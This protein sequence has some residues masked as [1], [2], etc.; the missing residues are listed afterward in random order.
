MT[1]VVEVELESEPKDVVVIKNVEVEPHSETNLIQR[2]VTKL[3]PEIEEAD[4][5]TMSGGDGE[6]LWVS[7]LGLFVHFFFVAIPR[8]IIRVVKM[9]PKSVKGQTVVITGGASGL[10]QRMAEMFALDHGA[11]VAI[12]DVDKVK[13]EETVNSIK[14]RGGTAK[15]W[16]CDITKDEDMNKVADEIRDEFGH[17]HIVICNAAILYFG[18]MMELTTAQL[19][20]AT[21]VNLMGTIITIRAFLP[22]MEKVNNGQ[23]VTVSSVAGFFGETYG[24]AYCPSKF[25]VRGVMESLE[26]EMRD[27]GLDGIKCTTV[28]PWFIRTPMILNMGMRPTSRLLPFMSV[29]RAAKQIIDAVLKEKSVSFVPWMVAVLVGSRS[30]LAHHMQKAGRNFLNARYEPIPKSEL[31]EVNNNN[32]PPV[33]KLT[34]SSPPYSTNHATSNSNIDTDSTHSS[35]EIDS[36]DAALGSSCDDK[37]AEKRYTGKPT[38]PGNLKSYFRLAPLFWYA[39]ILPALLFTFL[40]W[41]RPELVRVIP[42]IGEFAYNLGT[43]QSNLVLW[44]NIGALVAHIGEA[45]FAVYLC[46]QLA[47]NH[48]STLKWFIQTFLVGFSSLS[49]LFAYKK[50][51]SK[52]KD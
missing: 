7:L 27:R 49:I 10:G 42:V 46:D 37:M 44:I 35:T 3:E 2:P 36:D 16:F 15:Y 45:I 52:N 6:N 34:S 21:N 39:I 50:K 43:T 8:D 13:A 25:A 14:C 9:K 1:V 29:T 23:F 20:R 22:E 28:C 41:Y 11:N 33:T 26:N 12:I 18:H 4:S 24:M 5:A 32:E 40:T 17:V 48:A 19:Q 30:F 47:I 38:S 51:V 31:L